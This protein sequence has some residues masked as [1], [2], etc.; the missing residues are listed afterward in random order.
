MSKTHTLALGFDS[1]K[2]VEPGESATITQSVSEIVYPD[3]LIIASKIA[4]EFVVTSLMSGG[5]IELL[6]T[7]PMAGSYFSSENASVLRMIPRALSINEDISLS[8]TNGGLE[9]LRFTGMVTAKTVKSDYYHAKFEADIPGDCHDLK[10]IYQN[11]EVFQ[12]YELMVVR[13]SLLT[14]IVDMQIGMDSVFVSGAVPIPSDFLAGMEL[15]I[16]SVQSH[17]DITLTVSNTTERTVKFLAFIIGHRFD[18]EDEIIEGLRAKGM[19]Y[20]DLL[21]DHKIDVKG[22]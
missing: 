8:I 22:D 6:P 10:I 19:V 4:D 2:L 20:D 15:I 5:G 13:G 12:P 18:G 3:R 17:Q 11:R 7:L 14:D 1:E 16:P 21:K 9:P